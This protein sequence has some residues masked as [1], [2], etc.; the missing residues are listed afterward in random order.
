MG[1]PADWKCCFSPGR[2]WDNVVVID[3][4]EINHEYVYKYSQHV[5]N[6]TPNPLLISY[7]LMRMS[8]YRKLPRW[9]TNWLKN[10]HV[11]YELFRLI[12][13]IIYFFLR[14]VS[15]DFID[16]LISIFSN[17]W[18]L[19]IYTDN[20]RKREVDNLELLVLIVY[21]YSSDNLWHINI[22][23]TLP[24]HQFLFQHHSTLLIFIRQQCHKGIVKKYFS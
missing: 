22:V 12:L 19:P 9:H 13:E 5:G 2:I 6:L 24:V 10:F 20:G 15:S 8:Y 1:K 3:Y 21:F 16:E 11:P 7:K 14:V 18:H 4:Q 17:S 23:S